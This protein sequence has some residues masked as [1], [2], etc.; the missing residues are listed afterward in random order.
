MDTS[1]NCACAFALGADLK[2]VTQTTALCGGS[3]GRMPEGQEATAMTRNIC[4]AL[5]SESHIIKS[6]RPVN[7]VSSRMRPRTIN[8]LE[9]PGRRRC[10]KVT[11]S[12]WRAALYSL[13]ATLQQKFMLG[14]AAAVDT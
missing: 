4:R 3:S 1:N 7:E 6:Y 13:A 14:T 9:T 5:S 11:R 8:P 2:L 10:A 12:R